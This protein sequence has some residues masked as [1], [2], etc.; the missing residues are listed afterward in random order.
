MDNI[1][2]CSIVRRGH[3]VGPDHNI[4]AY[5]HYNSL[6][7]HKQRPAASTSQ[8]RIA[9]GHRAAVN[10]AP[11]TALCAPHGSVRPAIHACL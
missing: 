5:Q 10:S 11:H 6:G 8:R 4:A 2:V 1:Q 3:A 9:W 7:M